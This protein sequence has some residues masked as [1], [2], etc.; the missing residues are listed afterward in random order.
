VPFIGHTA[1][2]VG[3]GVGDGVGLG[4]AVGEGDAVGDGVEVGVGEG[5]GLGVGSVRP[6][7]TISVAPTTMTRRSPTAASSAA[8]ERGSI[9]LH[10]TGP[11]A[12][13]RP[14]ATPR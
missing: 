14:G 3:L 5:E 10:A 7:T 13:A 12:G 4:V 9:G 6:P 1:T 11:A 8:R 2:G